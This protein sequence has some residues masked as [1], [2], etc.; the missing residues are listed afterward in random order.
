M[1]F[2][3]RNRSSL[4]L[5]PCFAAFLSFAVAADS[6]AAPWVEFDFA[7][8]VECRAPVKPE[9]KTGETCERTIEMK[10]PVSVRFRGGPAEDIEEISIEIIG[11]S[12]EMHVATFSPTTRLASDLTEPVKTTTTTRQASSLDGSLG[13]TLPIP[14]AELVAHLTP[15]INAETSRSKSATET[16]SR[17]PPQRAIVVS[18]TSAEGRGVFFKLKPSTQTSLEGVHELTVSFVVPEDW[19]AGSVRVACSARGQRKF[20]FVKQSATLGHE[21]SDV[22]LRLRTASESPK[23]QVE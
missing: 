22:K 17:L 9:K 21:V 19:K 1:P 20:M 5:V 18:G 4:L 16:T 12:A 8:I 3:P 23:P 14:Y 6:S 15:T 7:R 10:L 11:I 2:I 13:G